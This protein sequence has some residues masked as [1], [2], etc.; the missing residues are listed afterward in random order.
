MAKRELIDI[1]KDKLI[2]MVIKIAE[3]YG[4]SISET[5][6]LDCQ[7]SDLPVITEED[8]TRPYLEKLSKEIGEACEE[9]DC[10]NPNA[11]W[12]F[13]ERVQGLIDNPLT[14]KEAEDVEM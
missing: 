12:L 6:D 9:Y 8:I 13:E 2:E 1:S 4:A 10:H 5:S 3:S 11:L 14:E 7:L